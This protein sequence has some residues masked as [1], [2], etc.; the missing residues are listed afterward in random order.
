MKAEDSSDAEATARA[1]GASMYA[2]DRASKELGI[3]LDE[4]R[5]GHARMS[6]HVEDWML[7]GY[8]VC[9]GGLLFALADTTMAFASC[10]YNQQHVALHANID[11]LRPAQAGDTLVAEATEGS[12]TNRMAMYTVTIENGDG[13]TVCYFRGRTYGVRG[14]VIQDADDS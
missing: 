14:Q 13:E 8:A 2:R 10:S 4:I 6:L 5:P 7:Q 3:K 12:R 11:F 1:A 9:H